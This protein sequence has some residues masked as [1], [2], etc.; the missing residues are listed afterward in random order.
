MLKFY[1]LERCGTCK[2]AV[3]FLQQR[4]VPFKSVAIRETPPTRAELKKML[5]L[6][7][8]QIRKLFNT[9]GLEYKRLNLKDKLAAMGTE[10]ALDLLASNGSLVKRPFVFI[11]DRG[12]VGFKEKEWAEVV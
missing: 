3:K 8:G 2:K 6:N 7:D 10:E 1:Q 4:G 5:D 9:S 11:K 12:F